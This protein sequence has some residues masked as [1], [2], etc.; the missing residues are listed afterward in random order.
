MF[1]CIFAADLDAFLQSLQQKL[2]DRTT[3]PPSDQIEATSVTEHYTQPPGV[4]RGNNSLPSEPWIQAPNQSFIQQTIQA[5]AKDNQKVN[6]VAPFTNVDLTSSNV[7]TMPPGGDILQHLESRIQSTVTVDT[8]NK[9]SVTTSDIDMPSA[10]LSPT[11]QSKGAQNVECVEMLSAGLTQKKV[12]V[13]AP[14]ATSTTTS[15]ASKDKQQEK[16]V[17]AKA[18]I[19]QAI[20]NAEFRKQRQ[21]RLCN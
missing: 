16:P 13:V 9:L 14:M 2:S 8:S 10:K 17:D 1:C 5:A 11:D 3:S 4:Q 20:L 19:K 7:Y 12:A 21:G 15:D 6:A 18:L